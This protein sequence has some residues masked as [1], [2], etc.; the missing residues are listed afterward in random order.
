MNTF[1]V[2]VF[3]S[4]NNFHEFQMQLLGC[5]SSESISLNR[6]SET[7]PI[8]LWI[9]SDWF[10]VCSF[11]NRIFSLEL[12]FFYVIRLC[13]L[14]AVGNRMIT[15]AIVHRSIHRSVWLT[16]AI[17]WNC[18]YNFVMS[19]RWLHSMLDRIVDMLKYFGSKNNNCSWKLKT[20]GKNTRN[21][22][23]HLRVRV[24]SF[25]LIKSL[26]IFR[27]IWIFDICFDPLF[28]S[29]IQNSFK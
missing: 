15:S 1:W 7:S 20:A 18:Q 14:V 12:T 8:W 17:A 19:R 29:F 28:V 6:I 2:L 11:D 26:R 4:Q 5:N 25:R 27:F 3:D 24:M 13:L 21:D 16:D 10:L 23:I 22:S 9:F